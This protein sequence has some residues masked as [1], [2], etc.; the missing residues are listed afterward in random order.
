MTSIKNKKIVLTSRPNGE[1]KTECWKLVHEEING[2]IDPGEFIVKIDSISIDPAMRGWINNVESYIPPVQINETMRALGLAVVVDS[3]HEKFNKGDL[4]SGMFGVQEYCKLNSDYAIEKIDNTAENI[5]TSIFLSAL[6][7]PGMT[8]YFGLTD[9]ARIKANDT[10]LI[11][12]AAG[13]VGSIAGQI[14]KIKGCT[15]IGIAGG[16]DKCRYLIEEAGFDDA[17]D[18]K[19]NIDLNEAIAKSCPKGIDVFFDNVGGPTLDA[20]I[21][22][23]NHKARITVCGAISQYN[24]AGL[25]IHAEID[26]IP[27]LFN[28]ARLEGFVVLDYYH[29][30]S[31]GVKEIVK[32]M[33]E[34]QIKSKED[35]R[36]GIE[37]FGDYFNLLFNGG[38]FGK[39]ILKP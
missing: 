27:I 15:V 32:W 22:H 21:K 37:N 5:N 2:D 38:N 30:Y 13:A 4:L 24:A 23:I 12:G 29:R 19:S 39:L 35:I 7:M 3:K 31:E 20:A 11:S 28:S 8:A 34:G 17:I 26:Y 36:H 18:Y 9:V 6:G 14:A 16:E 25:S 10:V 33:N 1:V